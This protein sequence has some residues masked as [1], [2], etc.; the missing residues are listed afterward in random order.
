ML[1]NFLKELYN[2][3]IF[4]YKRFYIL[5]KP[6]FNTRR[7]GDGFLIGYTSEKI[8]IDSLNK[9]IIIQL[10]KGSID[11]KEVII[12]SHYNNLTTSR[13]LSRIDLNMQ[14]VKSA[15]DLLRL[16]PGLFIAQHQVVANRIKN[17]KLPLEDMCQ[18]TETLTND[19]YRSPMKG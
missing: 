16:V 13:T 2:S 10:E 1:H 12:N 18:L 5:T 14:T 6:F 3:H 7:F 19:K 11:L 15:Q 4:T 9:P 8:K 17:N